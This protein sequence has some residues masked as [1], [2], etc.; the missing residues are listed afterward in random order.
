MNEMNEMIYIF[1]AAIG[2]AAVL[3]FAFYWALGRSGQR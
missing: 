2:I 1:I 3:M